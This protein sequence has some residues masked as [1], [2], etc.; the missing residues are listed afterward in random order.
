M[1]RRSKHTVPG[2]NTTSTADISFMLLIFFLVASSMDVDKGLSRQ[3]PPAENN[4][5]QDETSVDKSKLMTLKITAENKLLVNDK[6][7]DL[8]KLQQRLEI[9]IVS[10]G[11]NHLISIDAS[12]E[13]DYDV[14]FH[15]QNSLVAAYNKWRN[16]VARKK[17]GRDYNK[18][19]SDQR[20]AIRDICP[21]RI[22]ETYNGTAKGGDR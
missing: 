1:F 16:S 19:S 12:P 4:Q 10:R 20:D 13:S 15:V 11:R 9:F 8:K 3:L 5:K 7:M 18:L 6:P 2:L 21:Q 17:Y 22:A 14:Y